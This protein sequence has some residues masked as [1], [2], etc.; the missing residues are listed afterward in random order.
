MNDLQERDRD[1]D[2]AV[3]RI[4]AARARQE[5]IG[6]NRAGD[7]RG[8]REALT[9]VSRRIRDYAGR[10]QVLRE[11]VTE[12]DREADLMAAPMA[13]LSRKQAF[14]ASANVARMRTFDGKATRGPEA[15]GR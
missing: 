11:I 14:F 8:A 7:Y 9:G 10:D 5:A 6:R 13:E 2:R 15:G 3:A 4:F 1:V 12:L